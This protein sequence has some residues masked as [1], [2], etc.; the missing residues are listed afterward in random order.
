MAFAMPN[1]DLAA[2]FV[3]PLGL[4]RPPTAKVVDDDWS[5][6]DTRPRLHRAMTAPAVAQ[7]PLPETPTPTASPGPLDDDLTAPVPRG[8]LR[9]F[10]L[11]E[12]EDTAPSTTVTLPLQEGDVIL[13]HSVHENGWA[14]G[15]LLTTGARGWL[16]TNYCDAYDPEAL[17]V[18]L[19]ALLRV[20]ASLRGE[21]GGAVDLDRY[22]EC[23]RGM[24]AGVRHLLVREQSLLFG[25]G[26]LDSAACEDTFLF[27]TSGGC[28]GRRNLTSCL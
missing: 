22:G 13:I 7:T 19:D 14:D 3:G 5:P 10:C 18:L 28:L 11:F 9:A 8:F 6:A 26:K 16:P 24:I 27:P 25:C 12:P 17:R 20:W 2:I 21:C 4:G 1:G 23:M 15:T